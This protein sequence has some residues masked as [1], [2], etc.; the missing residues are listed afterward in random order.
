MDVLRGMGIEDVAVVRMPS[1]VPNNGRTMIM[2]S[3]NSSFE[4]MEWLNAW[5]ASIGERVRAGK[6]VMVFHQFR[7]EDT[8]NR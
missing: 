3:A 7:K 1:S 6:N 8:Y 5:A 4:T 2:D